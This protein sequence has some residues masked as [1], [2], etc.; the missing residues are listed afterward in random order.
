MNW[1]DHITATA[2]TCAGKP[3][4]KG[5]RITVELILSYL[6]SGKTEADI[7]EAYPHVTP[8]QIRAAVAFAG[9]RVADEATLSSFEAA[10]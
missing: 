5:T 8:E 10:A 2:D 1:R 9:S 6:A 4:I 7:L 3:R